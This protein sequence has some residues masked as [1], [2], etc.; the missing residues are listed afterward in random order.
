ML[1]FI[2]IIPVIYFII[3]EYGFYGTCICFLFTALW[4]AVQYSWEMNDRTYALLIFR[5][6]SVIACGCYIAIGHIRLNKK[7]LFMMFL[8]GIIWQSILCYIP[9]CPPFMNL[10]WA[11]VNYLSSLIVM[12]VVYVLIKKYYSSLFKLQIIQQ[13]GKASYNIFLVQMIYYNCIAN[14]LYSKVKGTLMQLTVCIIICCCIGYLFYLVEN[15]IT[16]Y[17]IGYITRNNYFKDKFL[18]IQSFCNRIAG[19]D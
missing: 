7:F 16:I 19:H 8:T 15:K 5:Y 4:E 10:S 1:Q 3:K 2:F 12:P 9:I 13:I 17:I 14:I 11:R 6:V 18:I